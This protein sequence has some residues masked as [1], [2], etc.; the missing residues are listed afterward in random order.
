MLFLKVFWIAFFATMGLEVA[1]G[2]CM[3]IRVIC[4]GAS[5]K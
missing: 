2:L 1:L 4:K 5:K 3:A